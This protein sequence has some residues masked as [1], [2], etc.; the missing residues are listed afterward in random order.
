[1]T[2]TWIPEL[3][4]PSCSPKVIKRGGLDYEISLDHTVLEVNIWRRTNRP[5]HPLKALVRSQEFQSP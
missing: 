5:H 3:E 4:T 1:M 2:D